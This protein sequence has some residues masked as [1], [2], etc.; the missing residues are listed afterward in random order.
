M[1]TIHMII[2]SIIEGITEFLPISSTGHL[3]LATK[4]LH[5]PENDFS[6]SFDIFIQLGAIMAV[7]SLYF[8]RIRKDP[9]LLKP[10]CIAFLPTG[11]LGVIFYK[12]IKMYLFGNDTIV[13]LM[14]AGVGAILIALESFWAKNQP[15]KSSTLTTLSTYQL[16]TIGFFQSFSMVPGVSRAAATIVGGMLVGLPRK[17]AVE[18][19]FLLAVPTMA[20]ATGLDLLK[21]AHSF[22]ANELLLL[23]VGFMISWLTAFIV[24]KAFIKFVANTTLIPFGY[25]RIAIACLYWIIISV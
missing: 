2:L 24:I 23:G 5:I 25:Y 11:I 18:F 17:E 12:L 20:A 14:L 22:T 7:V 19:S 16:L 1:N 9:M 8:S 10:I 13:V 6:K 4:L 15:K 21:S 3:I